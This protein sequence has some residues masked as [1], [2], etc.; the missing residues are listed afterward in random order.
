VITIRDYTYRHATELCNRGMIILGHMRHILLCFAIVTSFPLALAADTLVLRNGTRL[1]GELLGVH[2]GRIEFE[3]RSV[4]G[5]GRR[6]EFDRDEV[7]R[8]E[9]DDPREARRDGGPVRPFGMRERTAIVN[10]NSPWTDTSVD[11]RA[12]QTVY[13]AAQGEVRWGRDRRDGPEGERNSPSNPNR[14]MP[15]RPA[16]ALIGKVGDSNDIFFIGAEEG[17]IRVRAS[18][19]LYLGVNDDFYN[20]NSGTFRVVVYY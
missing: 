5:R 19:R 2:N 10:S 8:I 20:D 1:Q 11:V 14:P 9:F 17:P 16:A 12:G 18:G 7:V 13:F 3:E 15:N 4:Y 6:V